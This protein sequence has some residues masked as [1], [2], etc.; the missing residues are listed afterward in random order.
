MGAIILLSYEF[1]EILIVRSPLGILWETYVNPLGFFFMWRTLVVFRN[2]CSLG[3]EELEGCI[4]TNVCKWLSSAEDEV[5][6][7]PERGRIFY[8]GLNKIFLISGEAVEG[9]NEA[10]ITRCIGYIC[11]K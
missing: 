7:T 3:R 9:G 4:C 8:I 1:A 2:L 10:I 6:S 11:G 5:F